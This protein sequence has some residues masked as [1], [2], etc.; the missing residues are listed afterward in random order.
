MIPPAGGHRVQ[1]SFYYEEQCKYYTMLRCNTELYWLLVGFI[2]I[3]SVHKLI[4]T[5]KMCK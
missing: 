3:T 5:K 1:V 4:S 2:K